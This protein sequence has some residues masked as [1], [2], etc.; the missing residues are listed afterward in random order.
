MFKKD[1]K[2][3]ITTAASYRDAASIT[4]A[5]TKLE[6]IK[7]VEENAKEEQ[8]SKLWLALDQEILRIITKLVRF[9]K[10]IADKDAQNDSSEG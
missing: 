1:A 8:K 10:K 7:I 4:D 6:I 3:T 9:K 2:K 5:I